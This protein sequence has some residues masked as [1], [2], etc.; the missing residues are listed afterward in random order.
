M[1]TTKYSVIYETVPSEWR[2][3]YVKKKGVQY[4]ITLYKKNEELLEQVKF[5]DFSIEELKIRIE[6][7]FENQTRKG[8][9][10]CL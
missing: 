5:V 2:A 10:L 8:E 4:S 1:K 6:K 3:G 7:Y 9:K